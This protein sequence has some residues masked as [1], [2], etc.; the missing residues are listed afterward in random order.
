MKARRARGEWQL[1]PTLLLLVIII[2]LGS[3]AG[4][5]WWAGTES[6]LQWAMRRVAQSQPLT[7]EG[8]SGTLRTGLAARRGPLAG[9]HERRHPR[10]SRCD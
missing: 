3:V 6:S 10:L 5:W 9:V 2:V 8:M 1:V 4:L 7:A